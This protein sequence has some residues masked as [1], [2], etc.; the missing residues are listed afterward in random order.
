[1]DFLFA[2][3]SGFKQSKDRSHYLAKIFSFISVIPNY[4][5]YRWHEEPMDGE[6]KNMFQ[7]N[8]LN[9]EASSLHLCN[10]YLLTVANSVLHELMVRHLPPRNINSNDY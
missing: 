8:N 4:T 1:L 5:R 6:E 7:Y 3:N 10:S 2:Q 9:F